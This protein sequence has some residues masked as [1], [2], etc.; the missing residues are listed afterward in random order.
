MANAY[1][2][3]T[4][5]GA[6]SAWFHRFLERRAY[7]REQRRDRLAFRAM[8][9]LDD[10]TLKDVGVSREDVIWASQLPLSQNAGQEL[11]KIALSNRTV[12]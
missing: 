5:T 4:A 10:N 1:T 7:R 6:V 2:N 9:H 11:H 8:M 3:S 12:F